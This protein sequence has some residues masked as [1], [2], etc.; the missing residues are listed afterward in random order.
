M[1]T[2]FKVASILTQLE[3]TSE[4]GLQPCDTSHVELLYCHAHHHFLQSGFVNVKTAY[5]ASPRHVQDSRP[6]SPA[7]YS[8]NGHP[9]SWRPENE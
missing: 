5:P 7:L 6:H 2:T 1:G 4:G 3:V 9:S 8:N